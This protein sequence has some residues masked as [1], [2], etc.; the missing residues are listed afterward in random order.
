MALA[1]GL[2]HFCGCL[3]AMR[4]QKQKSPRSAGLSLSS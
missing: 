4:R 1:C 2:F 3:M